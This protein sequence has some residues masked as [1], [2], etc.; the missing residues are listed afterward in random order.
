MKTKKTILFFMLVFALCS[1][2]YAQ[3]GTTSATYNAG[4]N[5]TDKNFTWYN[6]S[7]TSACPGLLTVTIPVGATILSTDVSYDMT[8]DNMI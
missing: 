6:G 3:L 5:E 2:T 1:L 4:D 7:Q 8:S